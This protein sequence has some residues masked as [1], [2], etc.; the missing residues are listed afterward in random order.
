MDMV[1]VVNSWE[2]YKAAGDIFEKVAGDNGA[3]KLS[4]PVKNGGNKADLVSKKKPERHR[5]VDVAT[6]DVSSDGDC[7][8]QSKSMANR[9]RN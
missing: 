9:H 2:N 1:V 6:G 5:R 8:K 4:D 3:K 7:N